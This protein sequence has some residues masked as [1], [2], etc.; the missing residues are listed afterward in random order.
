MY[1][2]NT[3]SQDVKIKWKEKKTDNKTIFRLRVDVQYTAINIGINRQ[4]NTLMDLIY[5]AN[6]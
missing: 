5:E 1:N 2:F 6:I 4:F 3:N